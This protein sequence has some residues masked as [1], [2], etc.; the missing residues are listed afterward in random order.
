MRTENLPSDKL[1]LKI[2]DPAELNH[3]DIDFHCLCKHVTKGSYAYLNA[4][5]PLQFQAKYQTKLVSETQV[6]IPLTDKHPMI[7]ILT[8]LHMSL[9]P[10]RSI[11]QF[12]LCASKWEFLVVS[13]DQTLPLRIF[14]PLPWAWTGNWVFF[15]HHFYSKI[16]VL[17]ADIS[18]K[19]RQSLFIC[20]SIQAL[21]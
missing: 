19:K 10:D 2:G 4:V 20:S 13:S 14:S 21:Q 6:F 11:L 12:Q 7:Y 8:L 3:C 5:Y 18:D 1:Q 9:G 15:H 16:T 17:K